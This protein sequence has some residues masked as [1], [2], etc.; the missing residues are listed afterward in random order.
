MRLLSLLFTA[1]LVAA[2]AQAQGTA[3]ATSSSQDQTNR[4]AKPDPKEAQSQSAPQEPDAQDRATA[5]PVSLTRIRE[6]LDRTPALSFHVLGERPTF[7]IEILERQKLDELLAT[8]NFKAGPTPAGGVYWN[9]IQRQMFPAVDNPLRQPY[10]AFSQGELLTILVENLVGKY[11]AG[12]AI[13]AITSA[14]RAR[15]ENAAREEVKQA[16]HNYCAAQANGGAGVQICSSVG[17]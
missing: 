6:G 16:I 9:E 17:R 10:A 8:L 4:T 3:A 1:M 11:L 14:E 13:N 2:P 15:A 7:R 12:K 5:L